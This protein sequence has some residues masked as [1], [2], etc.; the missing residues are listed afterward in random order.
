MLTIATAIA[1]QTLFALVDPDVAAR[2]SF[3][4]PLLPFFVADLLLNAAALN[5][6]ILAL[7]N[8]PRLLPLVAALLLSCVTLGTLSLVGL[9]PSS[10]LPALWSL[11]GCGTAWAFLL[12]TRSLAVKQPRLLLTCIATGV[13]LGQLAQTIAPHLSKIPLLLT[14]FVCSGGCALLLYLLHRNTTTP[15]AEPLQTTPDSPS[16]NM[17]LRRLARLF[18]KPLTGSV[19]CA[20]I[21]GFGWNSVEAGSALSLYGSLAACAIMTLLCLM[22]GTTTRE[23]SPERLCHLLLPL[24]ATALIL[25]PFVTDLENQLVSALVYPINSLAFFFFD[26]LTWFLA[27]TIANH[28]RTSPQQS[29]AFF[30]LCCAIAMSL[31]L[32]GAPTEHSFPAQVAFLAALASYLLALALTSSHLSP[33]SDARKSAQSN[34][35]LQEALEKKVGLLADEKGLSPR[36]REVFSYIARGHGSPYIAKELTVS[37]ETV[38][39]HVKRIYR[40]LGVGSREELLALIEQRRQH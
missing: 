22:T 36:E 24:G 8:R 37:N 25:T 17:P 31:G 16:A 10:A 4:H 28:A 27:I 39:T 34:S 26:S 40:K 33:N 13:L 14:S 21:A 5:K 1:A 38:K 29:V 19:L 12:L 35:D 30:R 2:N 6:R 7:L 3:A 15:V 23:P 20:L 32:L 18:W 9:L 11:F